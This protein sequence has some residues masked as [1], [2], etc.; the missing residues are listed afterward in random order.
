LTSSHR[1]NVSILTSQTAGFR[2]YKSSF[3]R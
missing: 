2:T 3:K 1:E